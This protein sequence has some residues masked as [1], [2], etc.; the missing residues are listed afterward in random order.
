MSDPLDET[1]KAMSDYT[2]PS[3][4]Q[5]AIRAAFLAEAQQL[6]QQQTVSR[7]PPMRH[8]RWNSTLNDTWKG[9]KTMYVRPK[10][11]L[12]LGIGLVF[13]LIAGAVVAQQL[14]QFFTN[15]D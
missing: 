13:L 8:T 4:S 7:Q 5:P 15:S 12:L 1:L 10:Q 6:R 9:R 2:P 3:P 14:I 11:R